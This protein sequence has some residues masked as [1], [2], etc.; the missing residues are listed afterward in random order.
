MKEKRDIKERERKMCVRAARVVTSR[1][2]LFVFL[3]RGCITFVPRRLAAPAILGVE[4]RRD[5]PADRGRDV[6][7]HRQARPGVPLET[8]LHEGGRTGQGA[9]GW[10]IGLLPVW[11]GVFGWGK[12][13]GGGG[14]MGGRNHPP[15]HAFVGKVFAK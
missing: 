13:S 9:L 4:T 14:E 1:F 15:L 7:P 2:C 11:R 12:G 3:R 10:D 6:G 5:S 8:V